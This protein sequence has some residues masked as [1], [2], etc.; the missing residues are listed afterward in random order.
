MQDNGAETP[1]IPCRNRDRRSATITGCLI[2][3]STAVPNT[4]T[5]TV[6]LVL[7]LSLRTMWADPSSEEISLCGKERTGKP[8]NRTA[9]GA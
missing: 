2:A 8:E 9:T 3:D 5:W 4:M 1:D 7:R 6:L